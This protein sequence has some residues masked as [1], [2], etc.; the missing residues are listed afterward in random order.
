MTAS[1]HNSVVLH[2]VLF[3]NVVSLYS[4][5]KYG[6]HALT[7]L[8]DGDAE[9]PPHEYIQVNEGEMLTMDCAVSEYVWQKDVYWG[10]KRGS[11]LND[12]LT[13]NS[14]V[15]TS[16]SR[17]SVTTF[18]DHYFTY[19]LN[20]TDIAI[21]DS[22]TYICYVTW[23]LYPNRKG[24]VN[25]NVRNFPKEDPVCSTNETESSTIDDISVWCDTVQGYPGVT[26]TWT[27]NGTGEEVTGNV[28][29]YNDWMEQNHVRTEFQLIPH[30][31]NR[32]LVCTVTSAA[33]PGMSRTCSVAVI[34]EETTL[35]FSPHPTTNDVPQAG[36]SRNSDVTISTAL[37]I[38][39]L[40]IGFVVILICILKR[41]RQR[42]SRPDMTN[43]AAIALETNEGRK[44]E[45]VFPYSVT[46][47][48]D[49]ND[50]NECWNAAYESCI[51]G[52]GKTH[53]APS[54]LQSGLFCGPYSVTKR[55]D[56]VNSGSEV[57]NSAY[58]S[59]QTGEG[60][61]RVSPYEVELD[62]ARGSA[63]YTDI[64]KSSGK[65][66]AVGQMSNVEYETVQQACNSNDRATRTDRHLNN[67][68]K[69]ND[70]SNQNKTLPRDDSVEGTVINP[71]YDSYGKEH[72]EGSDSVNHGYQFEDQGPH[73]YLAIY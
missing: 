20:I 8:R 18:W 61:T 36:D 38:T 54:N 14:D 24:Y 16:D 56:H 27:V 12:W 23:F 2:Y 35:E 73:K 26:V 42:K 55:H 65:Q 22:G 41:K 28:Y 44:A 9:N 68:G 17:V 33:F 29:K 43:S 62:P 1:T 11:N 39:A 19:S 31:H 21:S 13:Q 66:E 70:R 60:E 45:V 6:V 59:C 50:E 10:I 3:F 47:L 49:K 63:V 4:G 7:I 67:T 72:G 58:E 64:P 32:L 57:S 37:G 46:K 69:V 71:I 15:E 40:F 25:V 51:M 52:G 5:D 34:V 48:P 53:E 30:L